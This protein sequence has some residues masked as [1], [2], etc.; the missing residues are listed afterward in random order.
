MSDSNGDEFYLCEVC[1]EKIEMNDPDTVRAYEL[2]SAPSLAGEGEKVEGH[3]LL[4]HQRC[5]F[6]SPRWQ[7]ESVRLRGHR[8][9]EGEGSDDAPEDPDAV[10][11]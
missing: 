10:V 6:D 1:G 5:Y 3:G 2:V 4:F 11:A 9:T 8:Y 7:R